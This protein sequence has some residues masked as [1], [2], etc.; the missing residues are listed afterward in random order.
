M[1]KQMFKSL[2]DQVFVYLKDK[3]IDNE[4]EPGTILYIDKLANEFGISTTPIRE[5]LV[6]LKALDLVTIQRN[7]VAVVSEM[8][9]ERILYVLEMRRLLETYGCRSAALAITQE[10]IL[11]LEKIMKQ[12]KSEPEDFE[13]YKHSDIELHGTIIRHIKNY[14]VRDALTNLNIHSRRIRYYA[15]KTPFVKEVILKVTEEHEKILEAIKARDP[16]LLEN[17]VREHLLNAQARTLKA[18]RK[19]EN[20]SEEQA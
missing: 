7:K 20:Q 4:L 15:E 6:K 1:G 18:L 14:L 9:E 16:D 2:A 19:S 10:E 8:G 13:F 12:V 11:E 5:A 3:I 17:T